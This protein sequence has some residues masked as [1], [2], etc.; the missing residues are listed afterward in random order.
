MTINTYSDLV[1]GIE[2]WAARTD[3]TVTNRVDEFI[4]MTEYMLYYGMEDPFTG[5]MIP[6]LRN[7]NMETKTDLTV[8][9]QYVAKPS[10]Y[11]EAKR[12]YLSNSPPYNVRYVTP[13]Q[14]WSRGD[15]TNTDTPYYYTIEGDNFVFGP[16]P[17][18][19]YTGKLL[20]YA[21][22]S[23]LDGT[24]NTT[25]W[26][27]INYPNIYL[28]GCLFHLY[29]FTKDEEQAKTSLALYKSF[30]KALNEQQE[31]ERVSGSTLTV[32]PDYVPAA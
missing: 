17:D 19:S 3:S 22:F 7:S 26:L 15:V 4:D 11:L 29:M 8:N 1:T 10:D 30:L 5:K 25:N 12:L 9:S 6:P 32:R 13:V 27:V 31:G 18:A 23:Q 24:T 21:K 28:Y 20:Y 16:S 14:F 2:N